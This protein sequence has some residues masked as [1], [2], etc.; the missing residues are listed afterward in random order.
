MDFYAHTHESQAQPGSTW[1]PLSDH[2]RSVASL[3]RD[4]AIAASPGINELADSAW[5]AGLLHD[6]GKYRPEFQQM[7][8]GLPVQRERTYHKQAGAAKAHEFRDVAVAF[9]IAGH[10]G[11]LPNRTDVESAILSPNG[12]EVAAQV[13][14]DAC[15]ELPELQ[16][17]KSRPLGQRGLQAEL[18]TRFLF[19]CLVDA[20]WRDTAAH[21]RRASGLAPE[22][23]PVPMEAE[24]WLQ[25]LLSI[26]TEKAKQ[27]AEQHVR[28]A[29]QDVLTAC[30]NAAASPVGIYSLTV[31]T[32]GGKTLAS[33]AFAL[34]HAATHGLRRI[35]YVAPYLT[36]LE[37]NEQAIRSGLGLDPETTA[38]FAHHSPSDPSGK[39]DHQSAQNDASVRLAENWD[40]PLIVTTNV[41]FFESLFSNR[42]SRC[43]KLQNIARSVVIL[44]EC[45]TLPPDLVAPTC[46]ML[47]QL[48]ADWSTTMVLCTATQ[49]AFGH[50]QLNDAERLSA[51]EII[52]PQA[53]LFQRLKRVNMVWPNGADTAL[54]WNELV[55]QMEKEAG[56]LHRSTAAAPAALVVVNS[57]RAARELF[58]ALQQRFEQGV[59]HL[60]TSMCPA[61]RTQ[62]LN[63]VRQRLMQKRRCFLVSTQL[64]EAGVDI[65]FPVVFRELA[66]LE[67]IIQAAGRCNREGR[68][69]D[70]DGLTTGLVIVFR[71]RAA[72]TEPRKYFP[73]DRWYQAGRSTLENNFLNAGRLPRIDAPADIAEYYTRLYH[74]G[75]LDQP[76]IQNARVNLQFA[77]VADKYQLIRQDGASVV[78]S[79]W[80]PFQEHVEQLLRAVRRDP[81]RAGFRALAPWQLNL[82]THELHEHRRSMAPICDH[83]DQLVWYGP[84]DEHLGLN[85]EAADQLLLI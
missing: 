58:T 3:G 40:A 15:R 60:S 25:H 61:H 8:R 66:P 7:L 31:P 59:F 48:A 53:N 52:P 83:L 44:D 5:M 17:I 79:T 49:P 84:Y 62:T 70:S 2:L 41:Q 68:L 23:P 80:P 72:V 26:L 67:A 34:K 24:K 75:S 74:T 39:G 57:R 1:Q 32:G 30:L 38:L 19:S 37:Q 81:C 20:D 50:E 71:S 12:R 22:L 69:R 16:A 65:D 14:R 4:N 9:A 73:P 33:L 11:G 42:T 55:D 82:R 35:I 45:Q 43:R 46:G 76:G 85:P 27:C 6:L 64:I 77:D 13:W 36:I 51:C 29:R 63:A 21:E 10:H 78:V 54:D 47:R 56:K 18:W 28:D